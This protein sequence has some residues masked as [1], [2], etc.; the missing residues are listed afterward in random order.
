MDDRRDYFRS[1]LTRTIEGPNIVVT[2]DGLCHSDETF[3]VALLRCMVCGGRLEDFEIL[4]TRNLGDIPE[5]ANVLV[6]DV[7]GGPLDHHKTESEEDGRLLSS[8]GKLWRA[9][10]PEIINIFGLDETTWSEIDRELVKCIDITD[11]TGAMNPLNWVFNQTRNSQGGDFGKML[12]WAGGIWTSVL[13]AQ[14]VKA[15]ETQEYLSLPIREIGGKLFRFSEDRF[16][17]SQGETRTD[18]YG[19]VWSVN[20]G[21]TWKVKTLNGNKLVPELPA[22][23]DIVFTH[24]GGWTGEV[25]SLE[26]IKDIIPA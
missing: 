7:F 6:L 26:A 1:W 2:H 9:A 4:R 17:P 11:N 25:K 20:G 16:L 3:A 18:L 19:F 13:A 5:G 23:G 12:S 14:K 22:Q 15:L 21:L 8:M 24:K 10:K